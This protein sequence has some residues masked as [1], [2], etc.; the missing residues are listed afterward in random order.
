M[1][2]EEDMEDPE[3]MRRWLDSVRTWMVKNPYDE[4]KRLPQRPGAA[5]SESREDTIVPQRARTL[6]ADSQSSAYSA[7]SYTDSVGDQNRSISAID[8][9]S[10]LQTVS[11]GLYA[12]PDSYLPPRDDSLPP[13][14]GDHIAKPNYNAHSRNMSSVTS[15]ERRNG[16]RK[17]AVQKSL[18][19]LRLEK[20]KTATA[21]NHKMHAPAPENHRKPSIESLPSAVESS[22]SATETPIRGRPP[23]SYR[24]N[25][26]FLPSI[27]ERKAPSMD[28]ERNSYFKRLSTLPS[29]TLSRAIPK[30]LLS[31]VD[32]IRSIL[33]AVSQ[34]YQS[35][36]H[37]TVY[38]IDERVSSVLLKILG[39][40]SSLMMKLINA[41]DKFDTFSKRGCPPPGVSKAVIE[42]CRENV[43]I[44]GKA[45]K[46]LKLQ[47]QTITSCDDIRYSR[48]MLLVLYGATAEIAH[49]WQGIVQQLDHIE[50][51]LSDE[52]HSPLAS[53]GL[54][55]PTPTKPL[56]RKMVMTPHTPLNRTMIPPIAEQPEPL[57]P[58]PVFSRPSTAPGT[59]APPP[60]PLLR[61]HSA[62]PGTS[63]G[64]V[65]PVAPALARPIQSEGR[66]RT[67][68]RHAGSFSAKDLEIGRSLPANTET[69]PPARGIASGSST[70]TPRAHHIP[71]RRSPPPPLP[72]MFMSTPSPQPVQPL[73]GTHSRQNS[74]QN[75]IPTI[76]PLLAQPGPSRLA[77]DA[78]TSSMDTQA[79]DA[80]A[81]AVRAAPT[82]WSM[83]EET[84]SEMS[85]ATDSRLREGLPR[86]Q[87]VTRR[88]AG[89]IKAV[90]D[91]QS[92]VDR[93]ALREDA[94]N[95]AKVCS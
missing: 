45:I 53:P 83:L 14:N 57:P 39:P 10:L 74:G 63:T 46:V 86:A 71:L 8:T 1:E 61:S 89:S 16:E 13:V 85:E 29:S 36:Q 9:K 47:L 82:V 33:F 44:F 4:Q 17:L 64:S 70:P 51:M 58:Q 76:T 95:F 59:G 48:Q 23:R 81:N 78:P 84:A 68:R 30:A 90:Q 79:L 55:T 87:D 41:L 3:A 88:L 35:L 2:P 67:S 15:S 42:A 5:D 6:S 28:V 77:V 66:S 38:A 34:I 69:S 11:D 50:P 32:S 22:A 60:P 7:S 20:G 52:R 92:G 75:G 26:E 62:Q 12:S 25:H 37:Y 27:S 94:H 40:A 31:V 73:P 18:P 19:D 56:P 54:A 91:G 65:V 24:M 80:M 93:K 72:T 49:S 21:T 43:S